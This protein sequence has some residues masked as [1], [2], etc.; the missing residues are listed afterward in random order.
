MTS[1][2]LCVFRWGSLWAAHVLTAGR[3]T[4]DDVTSSAHPWRA[5]PAPTEPAR[6]CKE[7]AFSSD[8][9]YV[10]FPVC[11]LIFG[12]RFGHSFEMLHKSESSLMSMTCFKHD[13]ESRCNT[14]D[15]LKEVLTEF[16]PAVRVSAVRTAAW[17]HSESL[18]TFFCFSSLTWQTACSFETR[19]RFQ[20]VAVTVWFLFELNECLKTYEQEGNINQ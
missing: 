6:C 19:K 17:H 7:A 10:L 4:G 9:V 5:G 3:T 14:S 2:C 20:T 12:F 15:G 13:H 8:P 1:G 16:L 18:S 11:W